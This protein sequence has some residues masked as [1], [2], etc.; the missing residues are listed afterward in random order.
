AL[1]LKHTKDVRL[2]EIGSVF[3]PKPG[4]QLPD[5]PRR[6]A[7]VL[8]GWR[9]PEFWGDP[10]GTTSPPL[11]FFD[12]KGVLESLVDALHL[13]GVN[14][15][16]GSI[17]ALHPAR[18]AALEVNGQVI[19]HFGELHPKVAEAFLGTEHAKLQHDGRFLLAAE[20]DLDVLR[21]QVPARHLYTP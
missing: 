5:E 16:P 6:L 21:S 7:L 4:N 14:Y 10:A 17:P 19:G 18:A 9:Q 12:L 11:D 15:Q 1:N 8:C 2:F 20:L 3:L 13:T